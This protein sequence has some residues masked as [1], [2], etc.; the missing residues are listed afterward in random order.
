VVDMSN[1]P[2]MSHA[3]KIERRDDKQ[4]RILQF[5]ADFEVFSTV[6]IV[7]QLLS[8]SQSSSRRTLEQLV[9]AG[10]LVS[11]IHFNNT[12]G[13]IRIY[14]ITSAGLLVADAEADSPYFE[15]KKVNSNFIVHKTATQLLRIQFENMN[16]VWTSERKIRVSNRGKSLK[17]IPDAMC[18][19]HLNDLRV[20]GPALL[21]ECEIN[22]KTAKRMKPI[23]S[24]LL[25]TIEINEKA[26]AVLYLFPQKY[27]S[28]ATRLLK[29]I[30]LPECPTWDDHEHYRP[31]RFL[32]GSIE[33]PLDIKFLHTGEAVNFTSREAVPDTFE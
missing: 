17:K 14:G 19:I 23:F 1:L 21:I 3:E 25:H 29:S 9:K 10:L 5:L 28:G 26:D 2:I 20:P 33:N 6:A 7:A 18:E 4:N 16:G 27:L 11:E 31:Y 12:A 13:T 32:I 22:V 24:E 8:V 15:L 30:E